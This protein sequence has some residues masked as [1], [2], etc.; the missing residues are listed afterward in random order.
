MATKKKVTKKKARKL[1]AKYRKAY[2]VITEHAKQHLKDM[3]NG[4][5]YGS[6]PIDPNKFPRSKAAFKAVLDQEREC[7]S[8]AAYQR[9]SKDQKTSYEL[10]EK[11]QSSIYRRNA[12]EALTELA[13]AN[14]NLAEGL[15]RVILSKD[16]NL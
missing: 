11:Y 7:A 1:V 5:M 10:S 14:A 6:I 15:S 9:G 16:G 4:I 12:V 2:P 13:K 3:E 8:S